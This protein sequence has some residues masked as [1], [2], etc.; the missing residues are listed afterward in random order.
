MEVRPA[1][2]DD[3]PAVQRIARAAWH[4]TYASILSRERIDDVVDDWYD[5]GDLREQVSSDGPFVVA[6]DG[7][8][9]AGFAQAVPERDDV[10]AELTR[11]YADP[12]HWGSGVGTRL[13]EAVVNS[14]GESDVERLWAVV[15]ADNEVGRAFYDRRGFEV[16]TRRETELSDAEFEVVE[17]VLELSNWSST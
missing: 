1:V 10:A 3:A 2:P 11:I 5:R 13:L 14:L 16:R 7:E 4:E 15:A 12:D 6:V 8:E 17:V 9:V